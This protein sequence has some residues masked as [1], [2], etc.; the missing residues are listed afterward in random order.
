MFGLVFE[1]VKVFYFF[2][3]FVRFCQLS[4]MFFLQEEIFCIK[5]VG[6]KNVDNENKFIL[7]LLFIFLFDSFYLYL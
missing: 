4:I 3:L 1:V 5:L 2:L 6:G 7:D